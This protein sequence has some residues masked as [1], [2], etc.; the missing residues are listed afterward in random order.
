MADQKDRVGELRPED[1]EHRLQVLWGW[2]HKPSLTT[3]DRDL[4]SVARAVL[5]G[6]AIT[7]R[8]LCTACGIRAQFKKFGEEAKDDEGRARELLNRIHPGQEI[9]GK[10]PHDDQIALLEVL[11]LANR[12]VAHPADGGSIDHRVG[13]H[14]MTTA[15]NVILRL[16][17]EKAAELPNLKKT[18]DSKPEYFTP[19]AL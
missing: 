5:D 13:E 12:A 6:C 17:K 9:V 19:I 3:S 15:I 1:W 2:R 11:F 7:V 18:L 8:A 16:L 4:G 10:L 14:A